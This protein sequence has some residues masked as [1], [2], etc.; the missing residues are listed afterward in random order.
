M[1]KLATLTT[2]SGPLPVL[3]VADHYWAITDIAPHLLKANM[4]SGLLPL[5]QDW[6]TA[7]RELSGFNPETA[8]VDGKPVQDV[9][10]LTPILYPGK[11]IC[12]GGNY[13]EH[14]TALGMA[15]ETDDRPP[16]IFFLKPPTTTLVGPGNTVPY[17]R[18]ISELDWEIE[19]TVV[20][21]K[22]GRHITA[23]EALSHVA[24]YTVGIDLSARDKQFDPQ[25]KLK[26]D[27]F[28]GKAFDASCPVGPW[29][30]PA[31]AIDNPQAL[32][33]TLH[34][35]D[36]VQ[37]SSSTA[38][39]TWNIAEQ[40]AL[41]SDIMTLEPG[42]VILTG[43]PSGTGHEKGISLKPGDRLHAAIAEIGALDVSI[44]S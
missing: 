33:L 2:P 40:I 3:I 39:M 26:M 1:F 10:F 34:V 21:G 5:F 24:G 17:P 36:A 29:I 25:S 11:V 12:V 35:N 9:T 42:D 37:Q 14:M 44:V 32:D 30:V 27:L 19:L 23:K 6:A 8:L 13:A 38:N 43:T 15:H 7:S 18:G 4:T 16:P 20:I 28:G 22:Q 31:S 41:I